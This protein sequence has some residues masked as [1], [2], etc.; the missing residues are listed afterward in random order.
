M[1]MRLPSVFCGFTSM[2]R[3]GV[4]RPHRAVGLDTLDITEDLADRA[5]VAALGA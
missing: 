1:Y 3:K 4:L 2:R 5:A